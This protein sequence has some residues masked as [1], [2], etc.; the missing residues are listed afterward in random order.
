MTTLTLGKL[1]DVVSDFGLQDRFGLIRSD[2]VG[3]EC[4]TTNNKL[5]ITGL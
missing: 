2:S 5:K 3:P 4:R 1:S